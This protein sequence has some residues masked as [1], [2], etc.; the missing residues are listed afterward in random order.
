MA[1]RRAGQDVI[2][3]QMHLLPVLD[4]G[5]G[6]PWTSRAHELDGAPGS[7]DVLLEPS[8]DRTP[9]LWIAEV[10][11]ESPRA[12]APFAEGTTGDGGGDSDDGTQRDGSAVGSEEERQLD[13]WVAQFLPVGAAFNLH[14]YELK[15]QRRQLIAA[16]VE[17][18]WKL[19]GGGQESQDL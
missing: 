6:K 5:L 8:E 17:E 12:L 3:R 10:L 11:A 13:P 2:D 15:E 16:L 14:T 7:V 1:Q 9:M 19:R 4:T 18:L